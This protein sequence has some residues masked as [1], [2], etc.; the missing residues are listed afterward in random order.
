MSDY[1]QRAAY[2][3]LEDNGLAF[4]PENMVKVEEKLRDFDSMRYCL[5]KAENSKNK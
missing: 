1:F 4:T 3:Y 2:L 5:A